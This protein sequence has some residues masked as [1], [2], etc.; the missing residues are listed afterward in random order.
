M[1]TPPM[2]AGP[3]KKGQ[4]DAI[5]KDADI[6]HDRLGGQYGTEAAMNMSVNK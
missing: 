6:G 2:A 3:N 1:L 4:D 5:P